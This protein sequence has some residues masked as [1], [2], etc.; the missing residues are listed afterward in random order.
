MN[1]PEINSPLPEDLS[2]EVASLRRQVFVLLLSLI[3]VSGT[4][5]FF[6][7]Y[8]SRVESRDLA[9]N[10]PQARQLIQAF[11]QGLPNVQ[12]FIQQLGAYG[13][14][15]PDFQPILKKYGITVTNSA[16]K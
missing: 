13:E 16:A 8:Q 7:F 14:T 11:N 15:H 4:M 10:G 9:N 12:K 5:T 1:E 2:G 6:F 3:I